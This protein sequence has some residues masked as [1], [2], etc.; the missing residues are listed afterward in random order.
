MIRDEATRRQIEAADPRHSVWLSANAGSG[1]TRVLTDRVARLLLEGVS[2][3][4]ILC[5]TYTKAAAAEMQNRLFARLGEWAMMPESALS[6]ALQE[7]GFEQIADSDRLTRARTLFARAIETPGGLKIQTIHSFC[8]SILRRFPLEAGVS[9][10]FKEM[11]DRQAALLRQEVLEDMLAG[12]QA[13]VARNML[14]FFA[15]GDLEKLTAEV[16]S[17]KDSF[18]QTPDRVAYCAQLEVSPELTLT[19]LTE[20]VLT[21]ETMGVV[22]AVKKLC[23]KATGNDLKAGVALSAISESG[24]WGVDDLLVLEKA[25]LTSTAA[26]VPFSAKVGSFPTKKTREAAPE[27]IDDL[28]PIMEQ[29]QLAREMRL[30]ISAVDRAMAIA[31][32]G[33]AFIP[34]YEARKLAMGALDFD[35]L[36]RKA[37]DLLQDDSVAQWVLFRLDG[38]IDHILV[39]EAQD[40]NP[41]QWQ[42]VERLSQEFAS[43]E[44]AQANKE[45]TIFVVG[46][47]K[48]S[49]YSFQGADPAAFGQMKAHF[50][51]RLIAADKSFHTPALQYSFRSSQGILSLVDA[52]FAKGLH[53]SI[54]DGLSHIA[55]KEQMPGRV[56]L[57]PVIPKAD[58]VTMPDWFDPSEQAAPVDHNVE[59]AQRVAT[60]I[61][62]MIQTETLPEEIDKTG[63][64]GKRAI[65]EGDF[66]ILVQ[67]RSDLFEEIIRACKAAGL[68]IAGADRLKVG[69]E[70]AVKDLAALLRFLALP[71]DDLSLACALRSPLFGWSE[72]A[73][74]TLAHHRPKDSYLWQALRSDDAYAETVAVLDDL[75]GQADY[76]RPYDLIE[77]ILIRHDGRRKLLAR[78]GAEAEDG[79]DAMLSQALGYE[80]TGVPSLT[81]FLSWV[82]TEDLE[83]KRQMESKGDRIRV[84]TVHGAKGLE[85]PI[86]ILPETQKRDVARSAAG[87]LIAD[88]ELIW[89]KTN[90]DDLPAHLSAKIEALQDAQRQESLRLLYVAMTRAEKWLIVGAA[91]EVGDLGDKDQSW[92]RLIEAGLAQRG[93][94]TVS[95]GDFAAARLSHLDWHG[96]PEVSVSKS[97]REIITP[98][99]FGPAPIAART[100]TIAP[101]DLPGAKALAGEANATDDDVLAQGTAIH[102]LLEVLPNVPQQ[103]RADYAQ[104]LIDEE[105]NELIPRALDLLSAPDLAWLWADQ[106]LAEV[107]VSADIPRLGRIHGTI[108]R[109]LVADDCVHVV[110]FKSNRIV[111]DTAA[112]V[113][114]GVLHQLAVYCHAVQQIYPD[115]QIKVAILWTATGQMMPID[116]PT[117]QDVL[118]T[119]LAS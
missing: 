49:I 101:S 50:Q 26:K 114:L 95:V 23:L 78:L 84:M 105:H 72:Q 109:L 54:G 11:E 4:N 99:R 37:R 108:D 98:R 57:W 67:R 19:D 47:A 106:A 1:K 119:L 42:V 96:L 43:G 66:L 111:P 100:Q 83:I 92:Y 87:H 77:R 33:R 34:R 97:A 64:Y 103:H 86:V 40:T 80:S 118:E 3:Q 7:L 25:F 71:E 15:S 69:A 53:E 28:N 63:Q 48:Q 32:F 2:P 93:T 76:L 112:H 110:D 14:A 60:Q 30:K 27:L 81:G 13:E 58:K 29:V 24:P 5:L 36:I 59:L 107:E 31:R 102:K 65:T 45:R 117:L 20:M 18:H 75:R 52:T 85:A 55:F 113:P 116:A 79:I 17:N 90:K 44:G 82:E 41:M 68:R 61:K 89:W 94:E 88:E 39:D 38:G 70:L 9:P 91:G 56:D 10:Q 62:R 73:L 35:D 12:P 8:A 46:D 21:A 104:E 74:F 51:S 22:T 115:Q 16:V 6:A